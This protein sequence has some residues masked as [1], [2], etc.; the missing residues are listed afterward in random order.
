MKTTA[1]IQVRMSSSRLPG[2]SLKI[3]EGRSILERMV[4]RV[5]LAESLD[6]VIVATTIDPS[7]D[8]ISQT[9]TQLG[10]ECFRG[11][12]HDV[13]DR[14]YQAAKKYGADVVVRLTGDCPLIDPILVEDV[15]NALIREQADFVCN[16]LPPPYARTYPIGLD[17]EACTIAALEEAWKNATAK[18]QREH[19]MPYL[20]ETPNRFKVIQLNYKQD[21]GKMRWTLDTVEDLQLLEEI[22]DRFDGR[23]DFSWMDVLALFEQEP[24]L[25]NINSGVIHKNIFE[26]DERMDKP[27]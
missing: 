20:Y 16:R 19:V 24:E 12:L 13:L 5:R 4:E 14:Y 10:I 22:Y 7:D 9:C 1:I 2:K 23:N 25:R 3:I 26:V 17:V 21:L 8:V 15:V 18:H 11:S 6:Q 27:A